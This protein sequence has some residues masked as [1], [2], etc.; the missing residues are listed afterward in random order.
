MKSLICRQ[1]KITAMLL[2]K[3]IVLGLC[4]LLTGCTGYQ[5][6]ASPCYVPVNTEKGTLNAGLSYQYLQ[7]GYAFSNHFSVFTNAYYRNGAKSGDNIFSEDQTDKQ[8]S[9]ELGFTSFIYP[10]RHLAF[11][12][13]TGMGI[14][15]VRYS[16]IEEM[17]NN[18]EFSFLARKV[19]FFIQ[20]NFTLRINNYIDFSVFYRL[21]QNNYSFVNKHYDLGSRS[22][23]EEYDRYFIQHN[24]GSLL[25][26]EPGLQFRAGTEN[27]KFRCMWS[28]SL[29]IGTPDIQ[30]RHYNLYL[31]ISMNL[32]LLK[33]ADKKI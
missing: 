31:G 3:E 26:F 23:P 25:F 2:K 29:N 21:N 32:N 10:Q 20:P 24:H 14:G 28:Q 18:Y 27:V 7:L 33:G 19:N 4:L 11:E 5:Y 9:I 8:R 16:N 22:E 6:V 17:T 30:Y 15:S 12:I 13:V 1:P